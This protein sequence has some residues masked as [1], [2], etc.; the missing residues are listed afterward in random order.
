MPKNNSAKDKDTDL[1]VS[2]T[3]KNLS[4]YYNNNMN[5]ILI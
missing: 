4:S 3:N 5:Y 2:S 1:E